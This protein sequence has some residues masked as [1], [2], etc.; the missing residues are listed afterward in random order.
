MNVLINPSILSA[1]FNNLQSDLSLLEQSGIKSIHIDVMD[2]NFVPNITF[3][4][5]QI[6]QLRRITKMKFDVH[7]M[8]HEPIRFIKDFVD[9]GADSITVHCEACKHIY[10]TLEEI[11]KYVNAGVALNPAT[12]LSN[13]EYLTN[14]A[15][16]ILIMTV[17]PGFG[18]Q[19][20]I[21]CME[22]KIVQLNNL[23]KEKSSSAIIQVDGGINENNIQRLIGLGVKDIVMGS[24][25]FK[26]RNILD[27]L[28]KFK[29]YI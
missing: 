10:R 9:A 5:E 12:P 13:I 19:K 22:S 20:Y 7:L 4:S 25:V 16:K 17:N 14:I 23:I 27:N 2:G 29:I 24:A 1:D 11:K 15:D 26:N 8:V 18:G 6:K 28:K 3:G 21:D